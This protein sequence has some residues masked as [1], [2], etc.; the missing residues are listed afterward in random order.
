MS[1]LYEKIDSLR[2]A[3]YIESIPSYI[4][5]N[6]NPEFELRPYQIQAFE[7]FVT[8]FNSRFRTR[9]SQTL[10]HMAT[11]SGKTLIMAGLILYLYKQGYR[12]FLFFVNLSNIVKKTKDNFLNPASGKYLF[13]DEIV[14]DG[15]QVRVKEV[16]NFQY[17][18][19]ASINICFTTTQKLHTDMWMTK[20]NALSPDDFAGG[21]TVLI[22]DEAHHLNAE[23]LQGN[24]SKMNAEER[25]TYHSWESTVR[26]I[27]ESGKEN[28]LLEFTATCDTENPLLKAAYS[29]KILFDYPLRRFR[30]D[31]YSKE[32]KTLRSDIPLR[33][34]ELQ[35]VI[36]SQYR[37]KVFQEHRIPMKPVILFKA[38]KIAESKERMKEFNAM[39]RTLA[40][41]DIERIFAA[42]DNE[43]IRSVSEYF[44]KRNISCAELAME[45]REDFSEI[46][47]MSVNDDREA[48]RKQ[49]LLN[50]L[51]DSSNPYR[52]IFEVRKLDEGWDVLNLFDIVRL[53]ETRDSKN[54]K[55]GR[56][57]V[58]EAQLIGRGARY[59]PFTV[60]PD[61]PKYQRK[62]DDDADHPLRICE[63]LYYHCQNSSR[64]IDE[65]KH[66]L[67]ETGID[68]D[69]AVTRTYVLK[70]SFKRGDF[71]KTG[72]VF[73]NERTVKSRRHITGL[74]Q[75]V[76]EKIY[77]YSAVSGRTA[78]D[79]MFEDTVSVTD[80]KKQT[81]IYPC[82]VAEIASVNYAAVHKALRKFRIFDFDVLRRYYP[83][84]RS[85]REFIF[86]EEYLGGI[87]IEITSEDEKPDM[88][89]LH[90]ACVCVLSEVAARLSS[91]EEEYEGTE[92]FAPRYIRDVFTDKKVLCT[93]P[94]EGG[95][96]MSQKDVS[97]PEEYRMDL[98]EEDWYVYGD[99]YGTGDEKAFVACFKKYVDRLK[100]AFDQV[101]LIRNERQL[102]VSSFDGGRRFEPDYLLFLRSHAGGRAVQHQIF[103]E[104][105]GTHLLEA[106]AWKEEF[107]LQMESRAVPSAGSS[108]DTVYRIRGIHFFNQETRRKEFG[109]DLEKILA[110]A[111]R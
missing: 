46:H 19:E 81:C 39:M 69:Q 89:V 72:L 95:I 5:D 102:S 11:G 67:R 62:Y 43:V 58:S 63:E 74:P 32:I 73:A 10:F 56:S 70:D 18:D 96:G 17:A 44:E 8:Y 64:Y 6:I 42:S 23:T 91:I 61:Q 65:L 80:R 87:R 97:V 13:A 68:L 71:Y 107:L 25:E 47:V 9:P 51:E 84:L 2:E 16:D 52:A 90:S 106:D 98:A 77:T 21:R 50:S 24:T 110:C 20:E 55:P 93:N 101:Y 26:S 1:F 88:A 30:A 22:S 53:Y 104:V 27:F 29:N 92:T 40:A 41:E 3:G 79:T 33:D 109:E 54:G 78:V 75:A 35:A 105:K 59:C 99:N 57:T 15:E 100:K 36:L 34:R 60:H 14:I 108:D 111:G 38:S 4:E 82:T 103:I 83:E 48:D 12:N 76:R 45:L 37:L 86:S 49:L 94:V 66:A 28:I 7:N 31:K 85:A